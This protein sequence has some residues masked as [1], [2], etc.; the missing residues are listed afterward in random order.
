MYI[1]SRDNN[2][3]QYIFDVNIVGI[4][5]CD[6]DELIN[7]SSLFLSEPNNKDKSYPN[8]VT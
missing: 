5:K 1:E 3:K 7:Q 8:M 6:T 2:M 4:Y